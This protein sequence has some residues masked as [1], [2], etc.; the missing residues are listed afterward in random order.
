MA[1]DTNQG[2]QALSE[3]MAF[4]RTLTDPHLI[5]CQTF[6]ESSPVFP[7]PAFFPGCA[8]NFAE[9]L[10]FPPSNPDPNSPAIIAASETTRKTVT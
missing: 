2:S 3:R 4:F 10:L 6:D 7:K 5:A 8:L 9:D 1:L